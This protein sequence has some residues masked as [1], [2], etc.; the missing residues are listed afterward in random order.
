[1]PLYQFD[2]THGSSP[3]D[4]LVLGTDGNFYGTTQ[5]GGLT[6]D[7]VVFRI[8]PAGK[9]V[10]LHS[11]DGTHG[12]LP[13]GPL[14]QGSDGDFYGTTE[15]GGSGGFGLVFKI[16]P[17]GGFTVIHYMQGG[18]EGYRTDAG[19]VQAT[20]G[21][22]YGGNVFGGTTAPCP[23]CG[24]LFKI[25]PDG[26]F[27][28]IHNFD[29]LHGAAPWVSPFQHTNGLIYG[30]T[31]AGGTSLVIN[32]KECDGDG[33]GVVYRWNQGLPPFVRL[34]PNSRKV[35]KVIEFLGE[36]FTGTTAVSFNGTPATFRV[37]SATYMTATVPSGATT[38]SVTVTT[39]SG[40]LTSNQKFR[41]H[42]VVLTVAPSSAPAGT[43]VV[44]TGTSF[45]QTTKVTFGG[46]KATATFTVDSDN[47]VTATVPAGA[48]AG[49][50]VLTTTGG[51]SRSPDTFTVTP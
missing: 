9:I 4:P 27:S 45:T 12:T 30:D 11:F 20:D 48:P 14:V 29:L 50:I 41:V 33:C 17:S 44:I 37:V 25:T 13:T 40:I 15:A 31:N 49:Y 39:P 22:L 43:P 46:G 16:T 47:Q 26:S 5:H 35:G 38:G 8:T 10:V 32:S 7:G 2:H 3:V 21:N 36:G 24:T 1:M 6:G 34:L 18:S 42:P 19:L 23:G 28:V 51:R